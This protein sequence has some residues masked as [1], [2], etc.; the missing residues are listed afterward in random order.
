MLR[1]VLK[2]RSIA[3]DPDV[4]RDHPGAD[5]P[6]QHVDSRAADGDIGQHLEGH[7][8]GIGAGAFR[9][10]PVIR[11]HHN[12]GFAADLGFFNTL[13]AR[14]L[15]REIFQSSQAAGGFGQSILAGSRG[16]HGFFIQGFNPFKGIIQ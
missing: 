3:D 6:G 8:L 2:G 7:F 4:Y 12:K 15:D 10:Y 14:Q 13:N 16:S 5:L 11:G 1:D 9:R